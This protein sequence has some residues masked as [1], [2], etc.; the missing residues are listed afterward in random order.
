MSEERWWRSV[1]SRDELAIYDRYRRPRSLG[2]AWGESALLIVDVTE[3]F[4]GPHLPTLEASA[5]VRTACGQPGWD[6][7]ERLTGVVSAYRR[8]G[9]PVVYAKPNW[10]GEGHFG[11]TTAGVARE[12]AEDP[13]PSQV[14]P[15]IT[16]LVI[17][18]PKASAFFGTA[19]TTYLVRNGIHSLV[20]AGCTTSG[21]VRHTVLDGAAS[22]FDMA[23]VEDCVF[24]RSPLSHAVALMEL[25]VKY[26]VVAASSEVAGALDRLRQPG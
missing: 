4:L 20:V 22:G 19:L 8:A 9:R 5:A 16:E 15:L 25:E 10:E 3:A 26:A 17:A 13:I 14:A 12:V 6:A 24:D 2:Y 23:V 18:K 7:V 11:G 21:C 1:F